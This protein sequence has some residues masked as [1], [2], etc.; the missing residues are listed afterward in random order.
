MYV[1]CVYGVTTSNA[2]LSLKNGKSVVYN[3]EIVCAGKY[4]ITTDGSQLN[5]V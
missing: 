5:V 1:I 4:F 2:Q 3:V